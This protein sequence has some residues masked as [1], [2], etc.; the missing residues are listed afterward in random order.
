MSQPFSNPVVGGGG[1]LVVPVIRSPNFS[2]AGQTGWAVYANGDA[3]FFSVT[4]DGAVTANTVVI[5]GSGDGV[6][7]YDGAP[8]LGSLILSLA[9]AAG[10]DAYGNEYSGPG[11]SLSTPGLTPNAIQIRPDLGA[12]LVYAT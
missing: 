8:A 2:L 3:Y 7:I 6:F 12:L 10:T 1:A 4:A 5:K 9:S 11:I